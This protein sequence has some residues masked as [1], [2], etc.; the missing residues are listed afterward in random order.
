[1]WNGDARQGLLAVED[2]GDDPSKYTWALGAPV[3]EL[4][5][6]NWTIVK[7]APNLDGAYDFINFILDKENSITDLE[8]HGYHTGLK[9]IEGLLPADLK[10][11]EMIFFSPEQVATMDAGAVNSAQDR[12][13]EIYNNVKAKAGA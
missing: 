4:W 7:G 10:Y 2:A 13:V 6:D 12:L 3:T 11:P 9:E 5:M 8:F 1:M